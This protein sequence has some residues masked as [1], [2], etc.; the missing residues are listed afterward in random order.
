M[1]LLVLSNG[2]GEDVI[3][4]SIIKQLQ[5]VTSNWEISALPIVGKGHAYEQLQ[6]SIIGKVEQMPSGGFVYMSQKHLW[7][8]IQGGLIKLT[9]EQIQAVK[10]WS[11]EGDL[12]LAVGDIVPLLFA[13]LSGSYY[14][15]VGTA[16]SEYYLRDMTGNWLP[17]TSLLEKK[18]GSVYHPWERWLM[19]HD[20]ALAVYPRDVLTT[21]ILQ[22]HGIRAYNLGNPMMDDLKE[23][24]D[25]PDTK[26]PNHLSILLLPGSRMPEA[27][28]NWQTIIAAVD[29][30]IAVLSN[31]QLCFL[32]AIAPGLE[33]TPFQE[34]LLAQGWQS[35]T[36]EKSHK[37]ALQKNNTILYLTQNAYSECLAKS[38]MAIAMSG[39]A[40]EQFVGLGKPAFIIPGAGPQFTYNFAEA[41]TR[42]L[43]CSVT[44]LE[45]PQQTGKAMASWLN[46]PQKIQETK[47]NGITRMG[48]TGAAS[49]IALHL[50]NIAEKELNKP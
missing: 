30:A 46:N 4:V 9:L 20:R 5:L 18:L 21:Q 14:A 22:H 44:L 2:H 27:L 50:T 29:N 38:D 1:K 34:Y 23:V 48:K 36:K 37:I 10:Q 41:Q 42:L 47:H 45:T 19:N 43:G 35:H 17:Q 8:D 40:T 15:F 33:I 16:K 26:Q 31:Y 24:V 12:V 3:A 32:A 11:K 6:I 28:G 39:T 13:W 49:K 25:A 7:Q